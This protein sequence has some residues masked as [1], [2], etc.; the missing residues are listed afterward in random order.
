MN[1]KR[2]ERE[3]TQLIVREA[4]A[5]HCIL[6]NLGFEPEQVQ[7]GIRRI[8]NA[9]PPGPHAVVVLTDRNDPELQFIFHIAPVT[10][11]QAEDFHVAWLAFADAKPRM[12]REQLDAMLYGSQIWQQRADLLWRLTVK[13]FELRPGH[14]VS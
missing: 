13:G 9:D 4:Y 2:R 10:E 14:M 3:R 8:L 1:Q 11:K 5:C 7:A 6:T 12:P